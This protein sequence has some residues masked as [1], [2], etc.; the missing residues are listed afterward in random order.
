[1]LYVTNIQCFPFEN[2]QVALG[3]LATAYAGVIPA[4]PVIPAAAPAV[5]AAA[6]AIIDGPVPVSTSKVVAAPALPSTQQFHSQDEL[7]NLAFGYANINSARQESGNT[8]LGT[9]T[10]AYSWTDANG[11]VQNVNY[12]AD[13]LGFRVAASNLPVAPLPIPAPEVP[14]PIAPVFTLVGPDPVTETPEVAEARAE[15]EALK[16]EAAAAAAEAPEEE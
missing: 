9:R 12:V 3:F 10:G 14:L 5:V 2:F 7:G 13:G 16:A 15:H 6:P 11:I 4:A 8:W 1:M